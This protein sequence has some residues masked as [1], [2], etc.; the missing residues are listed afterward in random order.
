MSRRS[1]DEILWSI[2]RGA[3][4]TRVAG[5]VAELGV[6]D[7][8]GDRARPV[9]D[10]AREVGADPDTLHRYLR[11]LASEGVFA[12]VDPGLFENT[13]ASR[14]LAAAA[15]WGAFAQLFG[16]VWYRAVA[17]LDAGGQKAFAE[18]FWEWLAERPRERAL[19]DL[20]MEE[21]KERRVDRIEGV[22]WRAG[23][24]VVDLGGGN[25]SLLLA[26]FARQPG[27]RGIVYDLP[28]T[29]RDEAVLAAAGIAFEEGSFFE[30]VPPADVYVL[31]TILHDWNDER[32]GAILR[33]VHDHAPAGARILILDSV[34]QPG[35]DPQG[36]KWLDIL[37]L[38]TLDG[39]ERT[40][41]EWRTLIE[42]SGLKVDSI[43]DRLIQ[44]S[45]R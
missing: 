14:Q 33:T 35:N 5:I 34:V 44:A 32:A 29:V 45:C 21:G 13:S 19:F 27:L 38:A 9:T 25:G 12:E 23:D 30:R 41:Q 11:A 39:R 16:G 28:E 22:E 1:A 24:T 18:D 10:V 42:G 43:E 15:S 2:C 3:I 17:D 36:A 40:E 26:L 37:M 7:A 8:L 4:A 6:T 31:A 20:A